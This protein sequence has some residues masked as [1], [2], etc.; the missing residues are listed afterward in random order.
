MKIIA[1]DGEKCYINAYENGLST[2]D[3]TK[4]QARTLRC[5]NQIKKRIGGRNGKSKV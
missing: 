1:E 4:E 2:H 3:A 5:I